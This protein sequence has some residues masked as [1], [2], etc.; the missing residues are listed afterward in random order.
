MERVRL[1]LRLKDKQI[2]H[3]VSFEQ[4]SAFAEEASSFLN[5]V[6][7]D[8][9]LDKD[10]GEWVVESVSD[11]SL[12]INAA[13]SR[14]LPIRTAQRARTIVRQISTWQPSRAKRPRR[15]SDETLEQFAKIGSRM[16][17][18]QFV[19]VE[20][21]A[22]G[23]EVGPP[24][25]V[26]F[27]TKARSD[28]ILSEISRRRSNAH[29]GSVQGHIVGLTLG[30]SHDIV[31][32]KELSTGQSVPCRYKPNLHETILR[33][34]SRRDQVVHATGPMTLNSDLRGVHAMELDRIE[35]APDFDRADLDALV[36]S[37]PEITFRRSDEG[38]LG[39]NDEGGE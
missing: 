8:L 34:L 38:R 14:E 23:K 35:P 27:L 21:Y 11:G 4:L 33:L 3:G 25:S 22:G 2:E 36:G 16:K 29:Y 6:T 10:A 20:L 26:G 1:R 30:Q 28:E 15:V 17:P 19:E 12:R 37:S 32:I 31:R 39:G 18:A 13:F 9:G 24:R 7:D 5:H